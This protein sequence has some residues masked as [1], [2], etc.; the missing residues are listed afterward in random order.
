MCDVDFIYNLQDGM[1]VMLISFITAE[2]ECVRCWFHYNRWDGMHVMLIS[3]TRAMSP[4]YAL[5]C[6]P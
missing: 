6:L 5:F 1:C 4:K 2:M 3:Y